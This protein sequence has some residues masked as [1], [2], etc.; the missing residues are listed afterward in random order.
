MRVE[1]EDPLPDR[2][3]EIYRRHFIRPDGT[4]VGNIEA[5]YRE[6]D[7][8]WLQT[9]DAK[10][11]ALKR[12][13]LLQLAELPV[14]R[15][16]DIGCGNGAFADLMRRE[17][18]AEVLGMDVSATAIAQARER[19][20]ECRFEVASAAEVGR[21]ADFRPTALCMCGVT[22]W[23]LEIFRD[24]LVMLK[25]H[26]AGGLLFHMMTFYAPGKQ[27]YGTEHFTNLEEL[28]PYFAEMTVLETFEHKL[29]K[30]DLWIRALLIARI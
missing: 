6:C 29:Y 30:E 9:T 4:F 7:D 1:T 2:S 11:S 10:R 21:F 17:A 14:R 15:V 8:P 20:P 24:V 3:D 25:R 23:I 12:I 19:Y 26:F 27:R 13:I 28:L 22:W 5:I 16:L 18:G